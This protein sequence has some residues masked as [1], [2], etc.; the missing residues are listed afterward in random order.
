MEQNAIARINA[1]ARKQRLE[2][3]SAEEKA[4][5]HALRMDYLRTLRQNMQA[6][7]QSVRVEQEDGSY[8]PLKARE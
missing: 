8:A 3:L 5:Q 2:G 7:L 1:L 6:V 4:E